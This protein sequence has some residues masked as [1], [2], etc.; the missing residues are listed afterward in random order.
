MTKILNLFLTFTMF[1]QMNFKLKKL[2]SPVFHHRYTRYFATKFSQTRNPETEKFYKAIKNREFDPAISYVK[3]LQSKGQ[4]VSRE[5]Y[6][7]IFHLFHKAEHIPLAH[8]DFD[9]YYCYYYDYVSL[10]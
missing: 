1:V 2:I 5:V 9:Y 10:K 4:I 7:S 8:G 3:S 6:S